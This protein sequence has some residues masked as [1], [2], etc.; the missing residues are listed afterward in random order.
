MS[1]KNAQGQIDERRLRPIYDLLEN[2]NNRKAINEADKVLKK[3]PNLLCA[4]ALKALALL[5]TGKE[6]ESTEIL[7]SIRKE[8]PSDDATLQGMNMCYSDLNRYDQICEL[9]ET[10]RNVQPKN[11]EI[12]VN[13]FSAYVRVG[14]YKKQQNTAITLT[15]IRAKGQYYFWMAMSILLQALSI[16]ELTEY[17]MPPLCEFKEPYI[18]VEKS[19]NICLLLN[20]V[21]KIIDRMIKEE[22]IELP[23]EALLCPIPPE[24][25][26][27]Y[28]KALEI[29]EIVTTKNHIP[30]NMANKKKVDLFIKMKQWDKA[31]ILLQ[32]LLVEE[33]DSWVL[34]LYYLQSV[35]KLSP[36]NEFAD[37]PGID[38]SYEKA[39]NF[40]NKL[41]ENNKDNIKRGP[42]LA[43]LE[44]YKRWLPLETKTISIA[45]Y[46]SDFFSYVKQW[47][48][49]DCCARDV[50]PY[51]LHLPKSELSTLLNNIWHEVGLTNKAVPTTSKQLALHLTNLELVRASDLFPSLSP[52]ETSSLISY[53][54]AC[55]LSTKVRPNN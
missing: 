28:D 17:C 7:E 32:K 40:I 44:L 1:A 22:K 33:P 19:E 52:E 23:G 31:N 29:L 27:K 49:V 21:V 8:K 26:G 15:K 18:G 47:G 4:K 36:R 55:Y 30:M 20:L 14:D 38:N 45:D 54:V 25:L 12:I 3:Q 41:I 43:K 10:A 16:D 42:Y 11:E 35:E 53:L 5:R 24:A 46:V 51:L 2:G 39:L 13:L 9:Y 37:E 48:T 34:M 50:A 6:A